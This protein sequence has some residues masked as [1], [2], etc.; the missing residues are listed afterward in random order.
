MECWQMIQ[1]MDFLEEY[2]RIPT[3]V[4]RLLRLFVFCPLN[5]P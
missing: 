4:F 2:L 5:P 3:I 1:L